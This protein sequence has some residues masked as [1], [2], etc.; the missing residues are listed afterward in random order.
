MHSFDLE[1]C[2]KTSTVQLSRSW[3]IWFPWCHKGAVF[4][5]GAQ[6]YGVDFWTPSHMG[7]LN[8][9]TPFEEVLHEIILHQIRPMNSLFPRIVSG[10]NP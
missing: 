9:E 3:C 6:I 4:L 5:A 7:C 8:F 1:L 2:H 10:E